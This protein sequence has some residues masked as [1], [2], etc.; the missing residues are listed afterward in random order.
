MAEMKGQ[1]AVADDDVKAL[2][3]MG[4]SQELSRRMHAFSNFAVSFSIIC[5]LAGGVTSFQLGFTAL[6]GFGVT[7]GWIVGGLFALIVATAMGQIASSYPTAGGLYHWS[8]ILGGR[9][10]G[11]ATAWIN[12]AGLIFV[13]ASVNVGVYQLFTNLILGN[14]FGIDSSTWPQWFFGLDPSGWGSW[15]Q[16]LGAAV[17]TSA[18]ALFNHYGIRVTTAL[19]DFS[20]YLILVVA[21]I[22]TVLMLWAAPSHDL[23]R[24]F[25]IS[26]FTGL[27]DDKG[28]LLV[29]PRV[30]N[31]WVV[32]GLGLLLPIYTVTGYDGSAHTSEETVN[33]RINVPKGMIN[34]VLWSVVFGLVLDASFILAMPDVAASAKQGANV[35]F[36]LMA[37][38][39]APNWIKDVIY[40]GIVLA[41][42]LCGLAALTSTSRMVFA[43]ARDGGL[44]K[45]L[46]TVSR[47]HRSPIGGIW[48]AAALTVLVCVFSSRFSVLVAGCAVFLYI[49]YA[50][51]IAAGF[52]AEK[53]TWTEFGPFRL[54]ILSKPF[55]VIT[56]VG[57][58]V[59]FAIG[60]QPP[61]D[62]LLW[63]AG[64]IAA[65]LIVLWFGFEKRRF[66]GPPV[67]AEINRRQA[68]LAAEEDA[69]GEPIPN[70]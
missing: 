63:Y 61:N 22:L 42:F 3:S 28:N 12:L 49:S 57:V 66:A 62:Q 50:M 24:L 18:G 4:Y 34:A 36:D 68:Q 51:P 8:S 17:I 67:G 19:I 13:I 48:A 11:W 9:G 43:F 27:A 14:I 32:F 58:V 1:R 38:L 56:V 21:L 2:H 65:L 30:E 39:A 20:G 44:P 33:A 64:G 37:N 55:A 16:L 47:A 52:F 54:G 59:L 25:T 60:I 69:L 70:A 45:P 41:N 15:Q 7:V 35:F 40:I 31:L 5:I 26:N 6:G 46:R 10:W 53:K 23:S 29:W